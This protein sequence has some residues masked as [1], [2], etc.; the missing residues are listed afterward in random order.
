[1]VR[2]MAVS[3]KNILALPDDD[4]IAQEILSYEETCSFDDDDIESLGV[5][6]AFPHEDF[7]RLFDPLIQPDF[8]FTTWVC[9]PKYPFSLG[10]KYPF[11]GIVSKFFRVNGISYIHACELFGGSYTELTK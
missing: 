1:M 7:F 8:V 6:G 10:L 2:K 3:R 9:F 4:F 5:N 11:L